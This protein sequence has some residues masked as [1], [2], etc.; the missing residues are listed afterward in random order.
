M[1]AT[2]AP[3]RRPFD[4][5]AFWSVLAGLS[6]V[7]LPWTGLE[8]HLH[9]L[10]LSPERHAWMAAHTALGVLFTV[11]V[12]AHVTLNARPLWRHLRRVAARVA[13]PSREA[14]TA[15]AL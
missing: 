15:L 12:V 3:T 10:E 9:Q 11:A 13:L 4:A 6:G 8:N 1:T 2:I 7:G 5:R 14:L